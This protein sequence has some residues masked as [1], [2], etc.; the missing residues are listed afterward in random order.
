MLLPSLRISRFCIQPRYSRHKLGL[1]LLRTGGSPCFSATPLP[2]FKGLEWSRRRP[3]TDYL[4]V[5]PSMAIYMQNPS[6]VILA[7]SSQHIR[8]DLYTQLLML[9]TRH[10]LNN[11][12]PCQG[13]Q[14][15]TMVENQLYRPSAPAWAGK[16]CLNLCRY[17]KQPST[18]L[19]SA[20]SWP[21][22]HN[23]K[24]HKITVIIWDPEHHWKWTRIP[25]YQH[26][27]TEMGWR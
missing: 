7:F 18:S 15:I 6:Y 17:N 25:F 10:P 20:V 11:S 21:G 16:T 12:P 23:Q 2:R 24:T 19:S 14:S 26:S 13:T 9:L 27:C 22:S 8:T 5:I 3:S 4:L 1:T